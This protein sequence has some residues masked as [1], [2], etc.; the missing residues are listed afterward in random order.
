MNERKKHVAES[1]LKLFQEKGIQHT[2]IQ[3]I[4][5]AAAISKGTFYNYFSSKNDCVAEILEDLRYEASQRRIAA[6]IGKARNDRTIFIEQISILIKLQEEKHLYR[7]FEA[8]LHSNEA[9]LKK[10]V[11][12]HRVHDIEWLSERLIEVQGDSIR[13]FAFE[14]V[15]LFTGM[16][17]QT[18]FVHRYTNSS[19]HLETVIDILLSYLEEILKKMEREQQF[20]LN[21]AAIQQFRLQVEHKAVTKQDV[22]SYAD[23]LDIAHF[24]EE[25]KD[26]FDAILEELHKERIRKA[27]LLPLLKPFQASA[28]DTTMEESIQSFINMIWYYV[29]SY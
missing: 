3:D 2:S 8:I 1:A 22:L 26:L 29:H 5:K 6:Q 21:D 16:L 19:Y 10:L 7:L 23:S 11:L 14:G 15:I 13:S 9:D 27:V 12:K 24:Y 20:L 28:Q 4:L 17:Q 18:L 25:Q